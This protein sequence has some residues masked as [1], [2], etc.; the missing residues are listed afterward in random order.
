MYLILPSLQKTQLLR[1]TASEGAP[2]FTS[3][4]NA[5]T[6]CSM[7]TVGSTLIDNCIIRFTQARGSVPVRIEQ[8]YLVNAEFLERLLTGFLDV[9]G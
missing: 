6:V 5:P 7:G 4:A 8:I 1:S 9:S 3:S 2:D